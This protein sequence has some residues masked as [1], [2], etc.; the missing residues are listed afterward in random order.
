MLD[1]EGEKKKNNAW[2]QFRISLM[3]GFAS[4]GGCRRLRCAWRG[5][6]GVQLQCREARWPAKDRVKTQGILM[7][8][9]PPRAFGEQAGMLG[10]LGAVAITI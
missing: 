7:M 1:F 4:G 3:A 5:E 9:S 10:T 6:G 8:R 2:L